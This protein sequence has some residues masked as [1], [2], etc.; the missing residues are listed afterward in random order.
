MRGLIAFL[1]ALRRWLLGVLNSFAALVFAPRVVMVALL[2]AGVYLI[3]EGVRQLAGR[4]Y[5]L[6]TW[7]AACLVFALLLGRGLAR[8]E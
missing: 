8:G 7:G 2:V 1:A 3:A 5:A 6:L 4:E